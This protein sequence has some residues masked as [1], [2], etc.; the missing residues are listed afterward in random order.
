VNRKLVTTVLRKRGHLVEAVEHGRAAIDA[1]VGRRGSA[2]D[3]VIMD[4]QMPEMGGLEATQAIRARE[5]IGDRRIPIVALPA[6]AMQGGR[7]RCLAAGMNEYLSKPIDV[8]LL[9]ATVENLGSGAGTQAGE[10]VVIPESVTFAEEDALRR[11][12]GDRRLLKEL[13]A[14]YR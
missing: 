14:L 10:A 2:F 5:R 13:V 12:S 1:L 8:D 3:V 9:I 7:G 4:L 6:P 11:T